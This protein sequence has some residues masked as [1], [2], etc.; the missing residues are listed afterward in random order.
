MYGIFTFIWLI[1][2]VVNVGKSAM[3]GSYRDSNSYILHFWQNF[4]SYDHSLMEILEIKGSIINHHYALIVP[5]SKPA[6]FRGVGPFKFPD[7]HHVFTQGTLPT[8]QWARVEK[9]NLKALSPLSSNRR[10]ACKWG[11]AYLPGEDWV[12]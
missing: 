5:L 10:L 8:V 7:F 9:H 6:I 1:F 3:H 12:V 2:L 4:K 11:L